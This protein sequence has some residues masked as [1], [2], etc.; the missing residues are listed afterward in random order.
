MLEKNWINDKFFLNNWLIIVIK[1]LNYMIFIKKL[2]FNLLLFYKN[3]KLNY[4]NDNSS[5]SNNIS[6]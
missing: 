5:S 4:I 3:Q 1:I 2:K 6:I